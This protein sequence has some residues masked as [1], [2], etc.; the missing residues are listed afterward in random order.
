MLGLHPKVQDKAYEEIISVLDGD[1]NDEKLHKLEYLD[2][3]I[4][5]TLRLFPTV[6][7]SFRKATEDVQ[8]GNSS[9]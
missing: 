5:E 7:I 1:L 4:K 2:R 6:P 8:I 3:V 9:N